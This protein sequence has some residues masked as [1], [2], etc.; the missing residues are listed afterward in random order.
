[1]KGTQSAFAAL[2][3][4]GTIVTWGCG[5]TGHAA[6]ER[7]KSIII[8]TYIRTIYIYTIH[9]IVNMNMF[10]RSSGDIFIW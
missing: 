1:M 2:K 3:T 4:D 5:T 7:A 10:D 8:H 9:I 6:E